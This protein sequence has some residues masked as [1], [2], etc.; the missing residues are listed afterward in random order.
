MAEVHERA[1]IEALAKFEFERLE[2]ESDL[3]PAGA[4]K[5]WEDCEPGL[6]EEMLAWARGALGAVAEATG[7]AEPPM[8]PRSEWTAELRFV[9]DNDKLA[10]QTDPDI[11]PH[12]V[13]EWT[14]DEIE[15]AQVRGIVPRSSIRLEILDGAKAE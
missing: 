9:T 13:H 12:N 2:R 10:A 1:A 6:H 4:P 15:R 5:T 8:W 7:A 14:L 3:R 11:F